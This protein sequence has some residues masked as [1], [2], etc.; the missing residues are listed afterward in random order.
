MI[1]MNTDL[2]LLILYL[3]RNE[4]ENGFGNMHTHEG[5]V[6]LARQARKKSRSWQKRVCTS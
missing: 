5:T 3:S 2:Y 6:A 4:T 1:L